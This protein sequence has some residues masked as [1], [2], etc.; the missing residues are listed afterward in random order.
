MDA[1]PP[2]RSGLLLAACPFDFT[3]SGVDVLAGMLEFGPLRDGAQLPQHVGEIFFGIL[4]RQRR[5]FPQI[6]TWRLIL[7]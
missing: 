3:E 1:L 5:G 4:F 2:A 7:G 6:E